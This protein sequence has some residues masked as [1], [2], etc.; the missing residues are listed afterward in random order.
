MTRKQPF[1]RRSFLTQIVGGAAAGGGAL[2]LADGAH[3]QRRSVPRMP[4]PSMPRPPAIIPPPV[5][6]DSGPKSDAGGRG[7]LPPERFRPCS[8][9]SDTG[10]AADPRCRR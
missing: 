1:N 4:S 8:S 3:G 5:D 7:R 2:L 9:D 6:A 10:R